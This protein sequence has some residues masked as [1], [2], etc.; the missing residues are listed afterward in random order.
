VRIVID[1]GLKLSQSFNVFDE[2]S[3]TIVFNC[4]KKENAGN[5]RHELVNDRSALIPQLLENM[6]H[7]GL[8]SVLV[9]GGRATLQSFID[10]GLWDEAR[11]ITNPHLFA[12]NGIAA[13]RLHNFSHVKSKEADRERI[14][15]F[16]NKTANI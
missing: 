2:Q 13:P 14:D 3:T 11:I 9:E 12:G 6:Y 7:D 1:P 5:L 16:R 15:Y 4:I 10:S 8:Q